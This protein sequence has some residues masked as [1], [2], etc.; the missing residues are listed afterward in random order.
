MQQ[1]KNIGMS[2]SLEHTV[3]HADTLYEQSEFS[4]GMSLGKLIGGA[5]KAAKA[6]IPGAVNAVKSALSGLAQKAVPLI[7]EVVGS[8][9]QKPVKGTSK[10]GTTP[11]NTSVES[12]GLSPE[13]MQSLLQLIQQIPGQTGDTLRSLLGLNALS[14][15]Q[16]YEEAELSQ[17]QALPALGALLGPVLGMLGKSAVGSAVTQVAGKALMPS[18]GKAVTLLGEL[19][20]GLLSGAQSYATE[21][22]IQSVELN[23]QGRLPF[24]YIPKVQLRMV[25]EERT[26][27]ING[28][29]QLVYSLKGDIAVPIELTTPKPMR[30]AFLKL[31]IKEPHTGEVMAQKGYR[32]RNVTNGVLPLSPKFTREQLS[33]IKPEQDYILSVRLIWKNRYGA[34]YGTFYV[35][36]IA[37]IKDYLFDSIGDE[38]EEVP[39]EMIKSFRSLWHKVWTH[40]LR[41]HVDGLD[42]ECHYCLVVDPERTHNAQMP[43]RA[44]VSK[45][46]FNRPSRAK[47]TSG[48]ILS[49]YVLNHV[50]QKIGE[51]PPL[52]APML[53]AL[54]TDEAQEAMQYKAQSSLYLHGSKG[55][56]LSI[57]SFPELQIKPVTLISAEIIS[58]NGLVTELEEHVVQFPIP[59]AAHFLGGKQ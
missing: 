20:S 48:L 12:G 13:D 11:A 57:W 36:P 35:M 44:Q 52:E 9:S 32:L 2:Q 7:S 25:D 33:G 1:H 37:F 49:P 17:A 40:T 21:Q 6:A 10:P 5:V 19:F 56:T 46:S 28:R 27:L 16:S 15:S 8:S 34:D 3:D 41:E 38:G 45:D 43:T 26:V 50:L 31:Q 59:E 24:K 51:D 47:L 29:P 23:Q 30:E 4:E 53:Q 22:G 58:D 14:S 18:A 54:A 42:V 39:F 55:D